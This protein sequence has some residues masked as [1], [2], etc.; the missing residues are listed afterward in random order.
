[1][2]KDVDSELRRNTHMWHVIGIPMRSGKIYWKCFDGERWDSEEGVKVQ[3]RFISTDPPYRRRIIRDIENSI[4]NNCVQWL[5]V[6]HDGWDIYAEGLK[7][8]FPELRPLSWLKGKTR[9][10]PEIEAEEEMVFNHGRYEGLVACYLTPTG[11]RF[12]FEDISQSLW[13]LECEQVFRQGTAFR[14]AGVGLVT[15]CHVLGPQTKA[16]KAANFLKKYPVEVIAR[17]EDL[18][19][20]VLRVDIAPDK[21]LEARTAPELELWEE[22]TIAGFPNYRFGDTPHI[23]PGRVIGFRTVSGI[24]RVMVNSPIIAGGSGGPAID[25]NNLVVGVAVTGADRMEESNDTE[26]HGIIPIG[27]L[28]QILP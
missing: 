24:R 9:L 22:I 2:L 3:F 7:E 23:V 19:L 8:A 20:A 17:S 28:S 5:V 16:F 25:D 10:T 1:M 4:V 11:F 26:N 12:N 18:D 13:V 27:T 6:R 14:L 15:C 21:E